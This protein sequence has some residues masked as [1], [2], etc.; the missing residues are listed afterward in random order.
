MSSRSLG[1]SRKRYWPSN[2]HGES[3]LFNQG[4]DIADRH[5]TTALSLLN[6]CFKQG[7]DIADRHTTTALSLLNN[8][9]SLVFNT[10]A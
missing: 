4:I 1:L 10:M 7:I 6:N 9:F 3:D 2:F 8:C 5:T